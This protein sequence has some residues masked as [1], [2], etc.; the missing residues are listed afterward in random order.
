L[1][2]AEAKGFGAEATLDTTDAAAM[3]AAAGSLDVLL[4]TATGADLPWDSYM[5]LLQ[6]GG[7][8]VSGLLTQP[9]AHHLATLINP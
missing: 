1:Q 3:S 8:L 2:V 4:C 6:R 9:L 5:S 7:K